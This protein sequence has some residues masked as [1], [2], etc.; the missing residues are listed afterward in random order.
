MSEKIDNLQVL[1][2][3]L[4]GIR[5]KYGDEAYKNAATDVARS[6]LRQ[7]GEV[8]AFAREAFKDT[9]DFEHL[10]AAPAPIDPQIT[11]PMIQAIKKEMPGLKS[12]AQFNAVMVAFDAL[13]FVINAILDVKVSDE[14]E[15]RK[16][17][18]LALDVVHKST[19]VTVQLSE[20]PEAATGPLAADCTTPPKEFDES[21]VQSELLT[22][23][24]VLQTNDALSQWYDVSR[25]K[26]DRVVT[27]VL[28]NQL[29]DAIRAK[30][31]SF[32]HNS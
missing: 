23:L 19:L 28:R 14:A 29:F 12:Q 11:N 6:L 32:M 2:G 22:E 16:A 9:V 8:E 15:G 20:V 26:M 24:E 30:R 5:T 7:G 1:I 18:D 21:T 31:T 17:L 13:K 27:Q 3:H 25:V 4:Q 10:E